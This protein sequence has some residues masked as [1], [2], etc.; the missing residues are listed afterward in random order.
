MEAALAASYPAIRAFVAVGIGT[1]PEAISG[2]LDMTEQGFH[3]MFSTD[4]GLVLIDPRS[5]SSGGRSY[6]S[7]YKHDYN[8]SDKLTRNMICHAPDDPLRDSGVTASGMPALTAET[9]VKRSGSQLTTYRLAV[10]ATGEYTAFQGGSVGAALSAIVTTINRVNFIYERDMAI[11]LQLVANNNLL[12]YTNAATDPYTNDDGTKMLT[13]N[14]RNLDAVIGTAN[15][16][17]GHVFSTGGGGIAY[18]AVPCSSSKAKGV[19]GSSQPVGDPFDIDYVAH[20]MGHQFAANHTFNAT[21]GSCAGNRNAGTAYEPGSGT[22]VMAYAGICGAENLQ[23]RSDSLFHAGSITEIIGFI[24]S[25]GGRSCGQRTALANAAPIASAGADYTIPSGTPF[26]LT[27]AA[28]DSNGDTLSYAWDEMD[29]GAASTATDMADQGSRPLFRS[30][31][32]ASSPVRWFPKLSSLLANSSELGER[33]P[34]TSRTLKFRLT[35]RD[36]H[37]GV[38]DDDMAITVAAGAGP[39][40]VTAPN[41]GESLASTA[42]VTWNVANTNAAP[43]NCAHVTVSLSTD[44]GNTFPAMLLA[45]A[46]NTGSATVTFPAGASSKARLKVQCVN[47]IF[48]DI[49]NNDFSYDSVAP[50]PPGAPTIGSV[51]A[52]RASAT[53]NFTIPAGNPPG[54]VY[55]ALCVTASGTT[56]KQST[57]N[58]SPIVVRGLTGGLAYTCTVTASSGGVSARSAASAPFVPQRPGMTPILMLLLD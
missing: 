9:P 36:Q 31:V 20:E 40:T 27:G 50:Q 46:P 3:A 41:G 33:L 15:Y 18:L 38:H 10:A 7:Y 47:N 39:F 30:V 51:T 37:G 12:I 42:S 54:T 52:G 53:V 29:L 23:S 8:P 26:V 2:R 57:G 11:R 56:S 28:S 21:S 17:L 14:Q 4:Q 35:V 44:G 24:T 58:S 22:T 19:T 5:D 16:D 43:V 49:T 13:E 55:T 45:S 25:G 6:L 1:G 32:P 48:F 34:T